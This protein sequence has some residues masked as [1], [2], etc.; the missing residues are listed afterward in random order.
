M[1]DT[2]Y[3]VID[4]QS[5]EFRFRGEDLG[6]DSGVALI[7]HKVYNDTLGT[8]S[9][10]AAGDE[11]STA[12][13]AAIAKAQLR[14]L[15]DIAANGGGSGGTSYV[16]NSVSAITITDSESVVATI[17]CRGK[18]RLGIIIYN[19]GN[20]TLSSFITKVRYSSAFSFYFPEVTGSYDAGSSNTT[21]NATALIRKTNGR[22]PESLAVA[23]YTWMRLNVE[24]VESIQFTSTVA[25]GSTTVNAWWIVE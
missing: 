16:E 20:T 23:A 13:L 19:A 11:T 22:A 5:A 15:I 18:S 24:G 7:G 12:T 8:T 9:D 25:T 1:P 17:D 6:T 2:S 4:G 14:E 10:P 3:P 21:G